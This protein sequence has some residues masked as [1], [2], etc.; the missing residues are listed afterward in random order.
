MRLITTDKMLASSESIHI[1]TPEDFYIASAM[2]A[3]LLTELQK[4]FARRSKTWDDTMN[5]S[6]VAGSKVDINHA[7]HC[8][9]YLR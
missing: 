6:L 9:S 8:F 4:M 3:S 1:Y 2:P 7:S 5:D